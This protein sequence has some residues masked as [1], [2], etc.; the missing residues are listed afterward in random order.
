MA[1]AQLQ[2]GTVAPRASAP[3]KGIAAAICAVGVF[4]FTG[5]ITFPL[6]SFIM[7]RHGAS[8]TFI[9]LNGAMMPLG[10]IAGAIVLPA[11]TRRFV[12]FHLSMGAFVASALVILALAFTRDF[13]LWVPL[14]FALGVAINVLFVISETW[15]NQLAPPAYRGRIMGLYVSIAAGAFA[16]GPLLLS[17]VGSESLMAFWIAAASPLLAVPLLLAA[18]HQLPKK[19]DDGEGGSLLAFARAAPMLLLVI[20]VVALYDQT[21]LTLFPIY[22]LESGLD[23]IRT[24][25]AL[26]V[27]ML[28][29][30]VLQLPLGWVADRYNRR[31]V[32][33]ALAVAAALGFALLPL[34]IGTLWG[35]PLLFTI[36]AA[37]FGGFT[38]AMVELG[39]NFTGSMLLAG[40]A[41][42]AVMWGVGGLVGPP[43]SGFSMDVFGTQGF[44]ATLAILFAG[45]AVAVA[46]QPLVRRPAGG[47]AAAIP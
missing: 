4:A 1:E 23:E 32:A 41:A 47:G 24:N 5:G 8:P 15:I 20:G 16:L 12:A 30:V 29:N 6:L 17:I 14:R 28:G 11:L 43:L 18:R 13:W 34:A 22:G 46:S 26:S 31:G 21:A 9:G 39:E 19:F 2:G 44:P 25:W 10:I 40:N 42:F 45:L 37:G 38:V 33:A 3:L 35:W 27:T 36:G 7:E